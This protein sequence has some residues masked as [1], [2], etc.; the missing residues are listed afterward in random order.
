MKKIL[1]ISAALVAVL[2]AAYDRSFNGMQA[3]ASHQAL[4]PFAV[5]APVYSVRMED[6]RYRIDSS[7][8][9]ELKN[10]DRLIA[11]LEKQTLSE[12]SSISEMPGFMRTFFDGLHPGK[13]MNIVDP[14]KEW[15]DG[16]PEIQLFDKA[17]QPLNNLLPN[18][19]LAYLGIGDGLA[20]FSYHVGGNPKYQEM[21]I[22]KYS[23]EKIYDLYFDRIHTPLNGRSEIQQYLKEHQNNGGC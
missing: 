10:K 17:G 21:V 23:G 11:E 15:R 9:W 19:Q 2:F 14:G 12:K 13:K 18:R 3:A 20:L 22:V 16:N 1:L 7:V 4:S 6:G 5:H 8:V